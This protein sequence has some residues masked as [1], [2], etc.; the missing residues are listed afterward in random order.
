MVGKAGKFGFFIWA[1]CALPVVAKF[2]ANVDTF[3]SRDL[4]AFEKVGG[5]PV[6]LAKI[7]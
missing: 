6:Y 4:A 3:N 7:R 1:E 5:E 2:P